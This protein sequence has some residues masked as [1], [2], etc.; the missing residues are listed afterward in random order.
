VTGIVPRTSPDFYDACHA[1]YLVF[2]SRHD[3]RIF[4][5]IYVIISLIVFIHE[6]RIQDDV[7]LTSFFGA[8]VPPID[9]DMYV[10]V[11]S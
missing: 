2:I 9:N 5:N 8:F 10:V 4:L 3:N 1:G 7:D 11:V 6:S